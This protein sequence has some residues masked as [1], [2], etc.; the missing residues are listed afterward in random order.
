MYILNNF[1]NSLIFDIGKITIVLYCAHA[2]KCNTIKG[3]IH[4]IYND[5]SSTYFFI[6]VLINNIY[7]SKFN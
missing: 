3:L 7:D 6:K 2:L 5:I 1:W 4:S